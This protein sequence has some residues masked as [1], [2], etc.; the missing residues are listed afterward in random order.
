MWADDQPPLGYSGD[1]A[2]R[3]K[4]RVMGL[5]IRAILDTNYVYK[6]NW[7]SRQNSAKEAWKFARSLQCFFM[8][9][10]L[11]GRQL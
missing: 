9:Y 2:S 10:V 8:V 5:S 11:V 4:W 6:V 1:L 3:L 7:A